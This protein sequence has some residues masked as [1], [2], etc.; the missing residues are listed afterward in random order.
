MPFRDIVLHGRVF[1]HADIKLVSGLHIGASQA[2][3]AIGAVDGP[4]MRD[5]LSNRPYIPGS[6]VRGKMRSLWEKT[7]G[8]IARQNTQIHSRPEVRIHSCKTESSY[9]ACPVC[10]IY[11]VPGDQEFA[12]PA[13]LVV[14]DARLDDVQATILGQA[15]TDLPYTEIKW[16]ATIDRVTSAAV[17]RQMERVPA[18]TVFSDLEM[19][20]TLYEKTDREL[21]PMVFEAMQLLEDDYLGGLGSRGSGKIKFERVRIRARS[22]AAYD[23]LSTWPMTADDSKLGV[24]EVL[25]EKDS[26]LKWLEDCVPTKSEERVE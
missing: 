6:S 25:K 16:E 19:V 11:G 3:L 1:I 26:L 18:G 17:P 2:G 5:P 15:R 20:F 10:R 7:N 8:E 22:R 12:M 9:K 14:R 13:R 21:L 4:V 24:Q 23:T